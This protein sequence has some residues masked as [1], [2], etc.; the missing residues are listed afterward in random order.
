METDV[1]VALISG[2]VALLVAIGGTIFNYILSVQNHIVARQNQERDI[3]ALETRLRTEHQMELA[4]LEKEQQLALERFKGEQLEQFRMGYHQ[5]ELE[6]YQKL[7]ALLLPLSDFADPGKQIIQREDGKVLLNGH[8]ADQFFRSFRDFFYSEQGI[9]LS[10]DLRTAI[11]KVRTFILKAR[12]E[13]Q[14]QADG[15]IEISNNKAK[16]IEQGL[17]WVRK[18][19]RRDAGLEDAHLPT[20]GS[21]DKAAP[22]E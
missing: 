2:I 15:W 4:R 8:L 21:S 10:K 9:F 16:D 11:F 7:W 14:S 17:D 5:K 1:V 22:F 19:I 20:E 6:A 18:T 3:Q 12:D 13:G